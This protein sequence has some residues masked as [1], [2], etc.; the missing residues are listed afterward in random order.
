MARS[1]FAPL[2][3]EFLEPYPELRVEIEPYVSSWD[4]EPRENTDVFF[5]VRAPNDSNRRV[6][7]YPGAIRG[8]FASVKYLDKFGAPT[9]PDDLI[10]HACVGSG[11]WK[12][13]RRGTAVVPGVHFKV[14]TSDPM[15]H[16]ELTLKGFGTLSYCST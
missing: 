16:L 2:L 3:P 10:S 5:K 1:I 6:R 15:V 13:S 9:S 4:Q 11:T 14:V 12:L 8:M 7:P